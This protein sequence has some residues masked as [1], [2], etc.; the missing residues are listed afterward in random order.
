MAAEAAGA[1]SRAGASDRALHSPSVWGTARLKGT[2]AR[3]AVE[4]AF[5]AET[6]ANR[7][8]N[9]TPKL[10]RRQALIERRDR[11]PINAIHRPL[12]GALPG[13][14]KKLKLFK[15]F[16]EQQKVNCGFSATDSSN[17]VLARQPG[18]S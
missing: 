13:A 1:N 15:C 5:A 10:F 17:H 4:T 2:N 8:V 16:C 6:E 11:L 12:L 7:P 14:P 9:G 18:L 3:D